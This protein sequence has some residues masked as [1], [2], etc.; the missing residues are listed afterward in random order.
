MK[1]ASIIL[2]ASGIA[3]CCMAVVFICLYWFNPDLSWY[4]ERAASA[5]ALIGVM[6]FFIGLIFKG[7]DAGEL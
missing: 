1:T 5:S 4:F 3:S 2:M 7:I 6:L